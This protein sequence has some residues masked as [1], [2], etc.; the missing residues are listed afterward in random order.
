MRRERRPRTDSGKLTW[1]EQE[2]EKELYGIS[3]RGRKL[4][5][6]ATQGAPPSAQTGLL[7]MIGA[8]GLRT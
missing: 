7:T 5:R 8:S 2:E 4:D 1:K 6:Q 3:S